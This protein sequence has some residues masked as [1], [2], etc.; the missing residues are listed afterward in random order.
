MEL[1]T[2]VLDKQ[3]WFKLII[4]CFSNII[5]V[6]LKSIKVDV[7]I[8]GYVAEVTSLLTYFNTEETPVEAVFTFPVDDGSAVF[9]F[10]AHIDGRHIVAE[11]QEREQVRFIQF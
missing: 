5:S 8:F 1:V 9:Q 11:I 6:P 2:G 4:Y 10:E 3:A 7:Q